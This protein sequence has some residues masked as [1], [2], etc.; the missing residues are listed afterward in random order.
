MAHRYKYK[1]KS[2][3]AAG[4]KTYYEGMLFKGDENSDIAKFLLSSGKIAER[5]SDSV[6]DSA[7][8]SD[9]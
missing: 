4:G 7:G 8:D 3:F 6:V 1:C 9:A 5:S 2:N